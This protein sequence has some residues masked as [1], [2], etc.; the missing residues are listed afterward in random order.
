LVVSQGTPKFFQSTRLQIR[1]GAMVGSG[2]Y[3]SYFGLLLVYGYTATG[4][5]S[6]LDLDLSRDGT[7]TGCPRCDP[8]PHRLRRQRF[9]DDAGVRPR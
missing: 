5:A 3:K 4:G 7:G 2:G 9:G 8:F 1:D 6:P